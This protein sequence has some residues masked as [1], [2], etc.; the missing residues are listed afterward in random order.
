M[1]AESFFPR[2]K[3]WVKLLEFAKTSA[4]QKAAAA[5]E[6]NFGRLSRKLRLNM[7]KVSNYDS[8]FTENTE[9][10]GTLKFLT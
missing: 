1:D 8:N 4:E 9:N 3:I 7:A 5:I 6:P 2:N 10:V